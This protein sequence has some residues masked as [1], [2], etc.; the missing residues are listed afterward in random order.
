MAD[1][2]MIAGLLS[3]P[4]WMWIVLAGRCEGGGTRGR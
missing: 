4:I 3:L 1:I 2:E